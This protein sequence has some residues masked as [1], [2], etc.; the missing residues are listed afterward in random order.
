MK[1]ISFINVLTGTM[2]A[3]V[4]Q[5]LERFVA[6]AKRTKR[7]HDINEIS[8]SVQAVSRDILADINDE[9]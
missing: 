4:F 8:M 1:T 6:L 9:N 7:I 5:T 2:R 3:A